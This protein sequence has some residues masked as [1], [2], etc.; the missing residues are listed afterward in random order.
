MPIEFETTGDISDTI[1]MVDTLLG[2]DGCPWDRKQTVGDFIKY[3]HNESQELMEAI[4]ARDWPHVRE[5][6]GDLLFLC[7]FLCRVAEKEGH[8]TLK[9]SVTQLIEKMIRRHPHV[10]GDIEVSGPDEVL[11]NWDEIKKKEREEE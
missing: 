7:V 11:A 8:F 2:E 3:I 5:E 6:V 9:E 1:R 10:F 4:E